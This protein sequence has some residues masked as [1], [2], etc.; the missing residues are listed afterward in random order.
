LSVLRGKKG[1]ITGGGTGIGL[2]IAERFHREGAFIVICGRRPDR[3][4]AAAK[5]ISKRSEHIDILVNS[6]GILRFA[7]LEE[8]PWSSGTR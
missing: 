6:A 5:Q 2:A 4:K 8:L 7:A 1:L 3:L